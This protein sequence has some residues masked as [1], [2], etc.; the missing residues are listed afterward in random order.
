LAQGK[1]IRRLALCSGL[2]GLS[3]IA[4]PA[5]AQEAPDP[6]IDAGSREFPD[7]LVPSAPPDAGLPEIEP[8]ITDSEFE[9]ALP[10]LEPLDEEFD[11]PLES[12]EEFEARL[13]REDGFITGD[14]ELS[15]PA[16]ADG[17]PIEPIGDPPVRD[18]ELAAPLPPIEEFEVEPVEFAQEAR[19]DELS[20]VRYEVRLTGLDEI[21][22]DSADEVRTMFDELSALDD[23]GRAANVA[24]L[25]ARLEEDSEL[26]DRLLSAGGW[27]EA[28]ISGRIDRSPAADG[29]PLIVAIEVSP[30]PQYTFADIVIEAGPTEPPDLIAD[31][32]PI[33][34]G[35]PIVAS[36]VRAAE[37][38]IA[39]ALPQQGYPFVEIGERDIL[40]DRETNDGVYTLP[41]D[42]GPRARFMGFTTSGDLAFDADHV[43]TLTRFERGDL[44]DST[45]VDD[46][47][48]A[49][50]ATG[51][52]S[53]VSVQPERTGEAA[54]DGTQYVNIAVEQDAGPPRTLA[55]AAGY[56][57]GQGFRVS[58]TWQHGNLFPP[59]GAVI[60]SVTLGTRELA[61]S[62][63]FR[64]SNAGRRDRT[65][66]A[67]LEALRTDYDAFEALTGR[68]A[69]RVSYDSTPIWQKRLTYAYGAQIIGT[70]EDDFI[71]VE[72][73]RED[74]TFLI[75]GLTGQLGF[76]TTD[77]L[78]DPR[79]GF[80]LATLVEPEGSLED[81]FSPYLRLRVD[82]SAYYPATDS[83]VLAGRVR[84]GSIQGVERFDLA[85]SRRFYAGGGGSVRGFSFQGLGP[86]SVE[87]NP[88][89]DPDDPEEEDDPFISRPIGGR[90]FNELAAEVRY[91]F[92]N[93]GVVGFVDAGQVYRDEFP[94][95]SDLRF[96]IGV[97][98]RYYTNFGPLR[99]DVATPLGRRSGEPLINVYVSI[100]Q[101]F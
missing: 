34:E 95:F 93:F 56:G 59:E 94:D 96:G 46:L 48:Q 63:I 74:R 31:N 10:S 21:S 3:M 9:E 14:D 28:D 73:V 16:L 82:G 97:G 61:A 26:L 43:E 54:G 99:L 50:I 51:L 27:Y 81:G 18:I 42:T 78:L 67:A 66:E 1:Q 57:T 23:D 15:L 5:L 8:V 30:G 13:E 100:G 20:E 32:L 29:Q 24:Q 89:F 33:E 77:S 75:G 39:F 88:R 83:I 22:G 2:A 44:Y 55:A 60:A 98:G 68:A 37:A 71:P 4:G 41:V 101:A 86:Q 53:S 40:L 70:V 12:I 72:G 38:Q 19:D 65:F 80:K 52:F 91:R 25:S 7:P 64:R 62:G 6:D 90:S 92:G 87:P 69:V 35:D 58:G 85:P 49:L 79:E 45:M 76:D 11:R 17:D 36:A 47:R 84:I